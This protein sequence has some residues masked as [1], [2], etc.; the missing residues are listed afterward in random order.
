[1]IFMPDMMLKADT[2]GISVTLAIPSCIGI[3]P[4]PYQVLILIF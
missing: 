4:G 1:M 2:T 3:N